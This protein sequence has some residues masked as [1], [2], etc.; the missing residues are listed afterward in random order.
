MLRST[1]TAEKFIGGAVAEDRIRKWVKSRI[2]ETIDN[3]DMIEVIQEIKDFVQQLSNLATGTIENS[4][5]HSSDA[6]DLLLSQTIERR[7]DVHRADT[8]GIYDH[9]SLKNGAE[10]IY[11]GKRGTSK[12]LIDDLPV[13]NR[14]LQNSKLRFY[15]FGPEASLTATYPPNALGQCW[16]FRQT[17]LKEQLK[18]RE[19]FENDDSVPNDFKRGNFGTL[20][21]RLSEPILVDS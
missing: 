8:T 20:T 17:P 12:S 4:D 19:L 16:S 18:E 1:I 15:G 2:T 9:A 13:F 6:S 10:I 7:L 11:G 21:I 14:I 5:G 3:E